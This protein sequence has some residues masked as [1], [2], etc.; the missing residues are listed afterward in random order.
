MATGRIE[1]DVE[2]CKGCE[3]CRS[4]CPPSIIHMSQEL[5]SKGYRPVVLLNHENA[6]TGCALCAVVCP[7]GCI[8]VFRDIPQ[9]KEAQR[10]VEAIA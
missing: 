4:A 10:H 2:R 1:I 7:D 6:C 8:T 3:L 5:N 9:K